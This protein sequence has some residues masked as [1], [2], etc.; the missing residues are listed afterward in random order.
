[1]GKHAFIY[2][3]PIV[4]LFDTLNAHILQE[5]FVEFLSSWNLASR[6][7]HLS[8]T[9]K[10]KAQSFSQRYHRAHV[11]YYLWGNNWKESPPILKYNRRIFKTNKTYSIILE[12]DEYLVRAKEAG[13]WRDIFPVALHIQTEVII[14]VH[15]SC[16]KLYNWL[17][18]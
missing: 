2:L 4:R 11:I 3:Y 9:D 16:V 6:N 10:K 17:P 8:V 14:Q 13:K 18:A 5:R 12:A 7:L 1:M 15:E